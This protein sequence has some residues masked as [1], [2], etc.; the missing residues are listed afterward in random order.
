VAAVATNRR[1]CPTSVRPPAPARA[2]PFVFAIRDGLLSRGLMSSGRPVI[3]YPDRS[4]EEVRDIA[5]VRQTAAGWS[6]PQLLHADGWKI[7]GC[8]VIGPQADARRKRIALA[9]FSAAAEHGHAYPH[10]SDDGGAT[11][12]NPVVIDD[13]KPV[14]RVTHT[15]VT[16]VIA[17]AC[18]RLCVAS[19]RSARRSLT[20]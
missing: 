11:L 16:E 1:R 13:G 14:G 6:K 9:W 2:G 5:V 3:V 18:A 8:P 7:A 15:S 10:F 20:A 4:P 12:G 17:R 19:R